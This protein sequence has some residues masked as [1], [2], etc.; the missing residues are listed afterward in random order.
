MK[1]RWKL[2]IFGAGLMPRSAGPAEETPGKWHF[3][4][5]VQKEN[6][7]DGEGFYMGEFYLEGGVDHGGG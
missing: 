5:K 6:S 3:L 2:L 7:R 4:L 1:T